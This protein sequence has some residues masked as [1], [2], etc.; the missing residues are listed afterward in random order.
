M[1]LQPELQTWVKL[2]QIQLSS[3]TIYC[4]DIYLPHPSL[5]FNYSE[6]NITVVTR[7]RWQT[8]GW[9]LLIAKQKVWFI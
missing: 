7:G 4:L 5:K 3:M 1:A 6:K 9:L 8:N 2:S